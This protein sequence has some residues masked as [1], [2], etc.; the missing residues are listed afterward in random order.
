M[1]EKDYIWNPAIRSCKNGIYLASIIVDSVI[2]CD[3]VIKETK[4]V[5]TNFKYFICFY[6]VLQYY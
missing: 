1:C 6:Y 3:E 2:K 5:R 4:T